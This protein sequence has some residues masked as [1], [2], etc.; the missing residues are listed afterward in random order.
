M[1]LKA[2]SLHWLLAPHSPVL[3]DYKVLIYNQVIKP[4]W[5]YG[6]QLYGNASSSNIEV[7]QRAQSKILRTI[8]EAPWF[9]SNDN[10]HKD[11]NVIKV[12]DEFEN[13]R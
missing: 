11:L 2:A 1:K 6:L 10:I 8:T 5:T 7:L 4:I 9:I 12:K 3:L 13:S